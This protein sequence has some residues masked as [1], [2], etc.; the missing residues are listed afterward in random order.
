MSTAAAASVA[1]YM[2]QELGSR[3]VAEMNMPELMHSSSRK[4]LA[5]F[6]LVCR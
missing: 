4:S 2:V 1:A 5:M 6:G 3:E